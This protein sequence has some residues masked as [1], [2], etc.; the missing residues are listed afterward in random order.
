[1]CAR[2]LTSIP[3]DAGLRQRLGGTLA[4]VDQL[5]TLQARLA[6]RK[7]APPP[8][9]VGWS[10][11]SHGHYTPKRGSWLNKADCEL[12]VLTSQCLD[13]RIDD[14]KIL[15]TQYAAWQDYRNKAFCQSKMEFEL[16]PTP[17]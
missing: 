5:S 2:N 8:K 13:R 1:M 6:L 12:G 10:S 17:L 15:A 14:Q 7:L 16:P 3:V 9:R 4:F 11:V